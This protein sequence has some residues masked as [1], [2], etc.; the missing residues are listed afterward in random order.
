MNITI[1]NNFNVHQADIKVRRMVEQEV[2]DQIQW[3]TFDESLHTF[4][5]AVRV[6]IKEGSNRVF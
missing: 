5:D 2:T 3:Y 4:S 6:G 1:Y